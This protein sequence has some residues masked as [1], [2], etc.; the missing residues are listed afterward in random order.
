VLSNPAVTVCLCGAKSPQQVDDHVRAAA[1]K[2][3][4]ADRAEVDALLAA[5]GP[6]GA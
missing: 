5:G 2:L 1:W 4:A 3:S 6:G